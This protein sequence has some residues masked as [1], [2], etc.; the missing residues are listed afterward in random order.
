MDEEVVFAEAVASG[1]AQA[2][3][4]PT[5]GFSAVAAGAAEV[6]EIIVVNPKT[7]RDLAAGAG[8]VEHFAEGGFVAKFVVIDLHVVAADVD[9]GNVVGGGDRELDDVS[10][11]ADVARAAGD[12]NAVGV[13]EF[14][15]LNGDVRC[16]AAEAE[17]AAASDLHAAD[18]LGHDG[19]GVGGIALAVDGDGGT[20]TVDTVGDDDDVAGDGAGD[21]GV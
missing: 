19:D 4:T 3:E 6:V 21:A 17:T 15:T 1:E 16:G 10:R 12:T 5:N 13:G 8:D 11:K 18:G 7:S 9:I 20:G 14:K 2:A